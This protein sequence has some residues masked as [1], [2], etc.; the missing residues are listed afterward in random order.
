MAD[1]VKRVKEGNRR[2]I[3]WIVSAG[4]GSCTTFGRFA[5]LTVRVLAFKNIGSNRMRTRTSIFIALLTFLS[6]LTKP[7]RSAEVDFLRDVRP[8]LSSHCFKCHG[9][10]ETTRKAN[11]REGEV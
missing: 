10:D 9:P 5:E 11:L 8:I 2:R 7:V 3:H 4:G 6:S 1:A